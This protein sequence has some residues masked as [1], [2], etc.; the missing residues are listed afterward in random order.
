M[1]LRW[2][3]VQPGNR[4]ACRAGP[5][6]D[7]LETTV[8]D[9]EKGL[10]VAG[11][12]DIQA[13]R[14]HQRGFTLVELMVTVA[15]IAIV[16]AIAAPSFRNLILGSR[17]TGAANE[18]IAI[19]QTARMT[20]VGQRATVTVCP[21]SAGTACGGLG[22][23]WIAV[24]VKGATTTLVRETTLANGVS[25]SSSPNLAGASNSF[26]FTPN[27]FS[28]V[29]ANS[30]G[31]VAVCVADMAGTNAVDLSASVGRV[32]SARRAAGAACT[33]PVDN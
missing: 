27:G 33:A 21:S 9:R 5:P 17:L 29:G 16:G 18:M 12:K 25:V 30:S 6:V 11:R 14:P 26:R 4:A 19:L 24:A 20:A 3:T 23:R 13:T 32:S 15:V 28:A 1:L 2:A 7:G 22:S 10:H 8:R 31:T